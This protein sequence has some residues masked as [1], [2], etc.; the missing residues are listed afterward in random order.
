MSIDTVKRVMAE[1][2]EEDDEI[3]LDGDEYGDNEDAAYNYATVSRITHCWDGVTG[4]P[5]V[6][7]HTSQGTFDFPAGHYLKVKIE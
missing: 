3:D 1:D 4:D 7:L 5:L 6:T 2:I